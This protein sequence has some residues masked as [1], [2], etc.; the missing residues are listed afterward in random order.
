MEEI[1][2]SAITIIH[3]TVLSMSIEGH[4]KLY[5]KMGKSCSSCF[6][7]INNDLCALRVIAN[8]G[9]KGELK[10]MALGEDINKSP[11]NIEIMEVE[12]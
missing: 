2:E 8:R 4:C 3:N 1:I 12:K 5:E 10:N 11:I 7:T 6:F 9:K